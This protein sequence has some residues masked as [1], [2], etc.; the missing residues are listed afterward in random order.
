[1]F[2]RYEGY[3]LAKTPIFHGGNEKTGSTPVL[4][5]IYMYC[6]ELGTE[7]KLPYISGN[8]IRGKLRRLALLDLFEMVGISTDDIGLKLYHALFAGGVLESTSESTGMIDLELRREIRQN[9]PPLSLFGCAISNQMIRGKLIVGHAFPVCREYKQFL[10]EWLKNDERANR[11]V[12]TFT[13][14]AFCTRKDDL[15]AERNE[16]EQAVQMKI[17]YECFIPGT[18]F[19]HHFALLGPY[20]T[21]EESCLGR[22]I[23]LFKNNPYVGGRSSI[24][25]GEVIVEYR[26]ELCSDETYL[27]FVNDNVEQ[28]K[29]LLDK[30]SQILS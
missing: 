3:L 28:I 25:D 17:D 15:R 9:I 14:E 5:T 7:V 13:D 20:S 23:M 26:E 27:K 12:R 22:I 18:K 11:S 19:Y 16:G 30:L 6:D 29:V 10:P 21:I 1:M 4:R 8:G 24:G 2:K